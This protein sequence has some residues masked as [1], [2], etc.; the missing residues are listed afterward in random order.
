MLGRHLCHDR[1]ARLHTLRGSVKEGEGAEG[2][3]RVAD[4]LKVRLSGDGGEGAAGRPAPP[5][6]TTTTLRGALRPRDAYFGQEL[7]K[8]SVAEGRRDGDDAQL[9]VRLER[10]EIHRRKLC[11]AR[12]ARQ[13]LFVVLVDLRKSKVVLEVHGEGTEDRGRL[14]LRRQ[15]QHLGLLRIGGQVLLQDGGVQAEDEVGEGGVDEGLKLSRVSQ[16][17][18]EDLRLLL[19]LLIRAVGPQRNLGHAGVPP[20]RLHH[21]ALALGKTLRSVLRIEH[22]G[23]HRQHTVEVYKRVA[24]GVQSGG[25]AAV[26]AFR[27]PHKRDQHSPLFLQHA[28]RQL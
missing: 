1:L 21:R 7:V 25:A 5:L 19:L 16:V 4:G 18:S 13:R 20:Q 24:D 26:A 17:T 6:T 23:V 12:E 8:V 10:Q 15:Q 9:P 2:A 11:R 22:H 14:L 28:R 27:L 3:G